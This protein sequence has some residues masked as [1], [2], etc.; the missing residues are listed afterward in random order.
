MSP[1]LRGE[2]GAAP[3]PA[4]L[5]GEDEPGGVAGGKALEVLGEGVDP[6]ARESRV[7]EISVDR[8]ATCVDNVATLNVEQLEVVE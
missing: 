6:R 4:V 7:F 3:C 8:Y 1:H 5:V 2:R